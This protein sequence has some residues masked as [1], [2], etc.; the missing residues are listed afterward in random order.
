MAR[1]HV[2]R[3]IHFAYFTLSP[4]LKKIENRCQQGS[5]IIVDAERHRRTPWTLAVESKALESKK[6]ADIGRISAEK[7]QKPCQN[8]QKIAKMGIKIHPKS[9]KNRGCVA[10]AFLERSWSVLGRGL[11]LD[12][13]PVSLKNRKNGIQK[14]IKKTKLK[15]CRKLIPKGYPK[16]RCWC[17]FGRRFGPKWG[18]F[19]FDVIS[20]IWTT[21]VIKKLQ[22]WTTKPLKKYQNCKSF[23]PKWGFEFTCQRSKHIKKNEPQ[24]KENNN[25]MTCNDFL[26]AQPNK[27]IHIT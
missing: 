20:I 21:F 9:M 2:W 4:F 6:S 17:H 7:C 5:Q 18:L 15:K 1:N 10:D 22:K 3:Y 12:L 16:D 19:E 11:D 8:H 14:R 26:P 13:P 27:K 25:K 24:Q 23:I